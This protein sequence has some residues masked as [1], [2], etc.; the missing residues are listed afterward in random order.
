MNY[1]AHIYLSGD[2]KDLLVGNFMADSIKGKRYEE[3]PDGIKRGIL[4][5]RFIDD[6]T[7]HHPICIETKILLRPKYHK[8]SPILSDIIYDHFLARLWA[9][10]HAVPLDKFVDDFYAF[11]QT[12]WDELTPR[13]QY[14]MP[15]MIKQNWLYNYQ[16][17]VGLQNVLNGMSRRVKGGEIL[18]EGWTDL[19]EHYAEI[20][21][22]FERFFGAL[23]Q[24]V[25][26]YVTTH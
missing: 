25:S 22:Q 11:I 12:R 5:H 19:E 13:I 8:L 24:A 21:D 7:D 26:Q 1:L 3:Y 18:K 2:D 4:L 10:Y 23:E 14:M 16:F 17:K 20:Q 9:N 15:Y 6:F